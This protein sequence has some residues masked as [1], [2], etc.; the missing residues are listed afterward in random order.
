MLLKPDMP[1]PPPP[2][3]IG[4]LSVVGAGPERLGTADTEG[5]GR[6]RIIDREEAA[7]IIQ[8][9]WRKHIVRDK[10]ITNL[11]TIKSCLRSFI[12]MPQ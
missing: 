10:I 11:C 1:R 6:K 12:G 9:S 3:T 5:S 8:R 4:G 7:Q 2:T